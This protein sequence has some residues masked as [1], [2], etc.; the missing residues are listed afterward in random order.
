MIRDQLG[1][2]AIERGLYRVHVAR[3]ATAADLLVAEMFPEYGGRIRCVGFDWLGRQLAADLPLPVDDPP[4]L[5]FEPGSGRVFEAPT[6]LSEFHD[7]GLIEVR[8]E[9]LAVAFYLEWRSANP[10]MDQLD[11]SQCVGFRIPL[12]LG[13]EGSTPNLEVTA[14]DFYWTLSGQLWATGSRSDSGHTSGRSADRCNKSIRITEC[15]PQGH[16]ERAGP[17]WARNCHSLATSG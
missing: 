1:G 14:L 3:S 17:L 15:P 4:V 8:E 6:P 5:L 16:S 9:A 2:I 12:F 7:R 11:F 10:G 13:G